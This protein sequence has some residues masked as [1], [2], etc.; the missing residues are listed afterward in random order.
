MDCTGS[1][2]SYIASAT[3]N[4]ELICEEIVKSEKLPSAEALRLAVVAY[5]DHPPQD[6]SYITKTCNFTS[7]VPQVKEFLKNLYASGGGDGPEAV[8][9]AMKEC[10]FLEWR[11]ESTKMSVLLVFSRIC[12]L[13]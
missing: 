4:I 3:T 2:G 9:A 13:T 11:E 12:R 7:A 5:R 1:M 10:M 8:T 6:V